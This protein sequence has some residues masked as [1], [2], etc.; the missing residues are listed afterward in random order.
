MATARETRPLSLLDGQMIGRP[1]CHSVGGW[2][3]RLLLAVICA[4]SSRLGPVTSGFECMV[5]ELLF[6]PLQQHW[7]STEKKNAKCSTARETGSS[8][9]KEG[10]EC[11][12]KTGCDGRTE[13]GFGSAVESHGTAPLASNQVASRERRARDNCTNAPLHRDLTLVFSGCPFFFSS[14]WR[15]EAFECEFM[16]VGRA[17]CQI[18]ST[19]RTA[20]A[21]SVFD[22][23]PA[24]QPHV[25]TPGFPRFPSS[26]QLL[27]NATYA[28]RNEFVALLRHVT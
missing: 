6:M 25:L 16:V 8:L 1:Q 19:P 11:F 9:L 20:R 18:V 22:F 7:P 10:G 14:A 26:C 23:R 3:D 2:C 15:I 13:A 17:A 24:R 5:A 21:T 28:R 27:R 12:V 4:L